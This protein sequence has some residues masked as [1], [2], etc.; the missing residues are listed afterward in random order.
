MS[1]FVHADP[2]PSGNDAALA[3][4][5]VAR[6][7]AL[8]PVLAER[9]RQT[10]ADGRVSDDTT[11]LLREAGIFRLGQ[12]LAFGGSAQP[13]STML[14]VGFEIGRACGSTGWCAMIGAVNA[15]LASYWPIEAQREIWGDAPDN[16]VIGT[17]VPTGQCEPV[18]GGYQVHGR[19]PFASNCD[20]ADWIFVS[21]SLPASG[22][23]PADVGW[24]MVPRTELSID[25][26]S[27]RV[28]G[29][30][31]TGSK[32][33]FSDKPLFV[34]LHRVVRFSDVV[35]VS[36]PGRAVEGNVMASF[37]FT[38]FGATTLVAPLLGMAQGGLDWYIE[39]MAKKARTSL[40]PG[41]AGLV[42]HS[43]FVQARVGAASAAIDAAMAL[44][45]TSL[46]PA[47]AK[48]MGGGTLDNAERIRIRRDIGFAAQQAAHSINLLFEGA[49]A[50]ATSLDTPIQRYWRDINAAARHASLDVQ[51]INAL[52]GEE[53][54]GLPPTGQF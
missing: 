27:W 40:K 32:T 52:F 34:P 4:E 9:A 53:R 10:E 51:A 11:R 35:R 16:L 44:L 38:T 6:A 42:A 3:D 47:E 29:M 8:R 17:F 22:D 39:T 37:G 30:Q 14:R 13:P 46:R 48:I 1:Q 24:F 15:W 54:F 21:A 7:A 49:G 41:G 2:N 19:W 33:L 28:S 25:H 5:V 50:S 43:P 36:T 12:P 26:D 23:R 20:N 45:L 31:G 18:D